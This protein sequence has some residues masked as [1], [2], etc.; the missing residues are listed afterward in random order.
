VDRLP[1]SLD[2]LLALLEQVAALPPERADP[3]VFA[4]CHELETATRN[5]S[6]EAIRNRVARE[7]P[8]LLERYDNAVTR[9]KPKLHR[10]KALLAHI[11]CD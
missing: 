2:L 10:I 8:D 5:R 3:E 4:M 6:F 11:F 7:R 9:A 1:G